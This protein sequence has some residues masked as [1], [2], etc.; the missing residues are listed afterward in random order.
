MEHPCLCLCAPLLAAREPSVRLRLSPRTLS[1]TAR[2][3]CSSAAQPSAPSRGAL[4]SRDLSHFL[5]LLPIITTSTPRAALFQA[6]LSLPL[7]SVIHYQKK[8]E[9]KKRNSKSDSIVSNDD[10]LHTIRT[11]SVPCLSVPVHPKTP[12][13]FQ[14]ICIFLSSHRHRKPEKETRGYS[15]P[16]VHDF[17]R[18]F[19][20]TL[21]TLHWIPIF[22][23]PQRNELRENYFIRTIISDSECVWQLFND[24]NLVNSKFCS[25]FL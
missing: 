22:L 20:F 18:R 24:Q 7:P 11:R 3:S 15:F 23:F 8:K 5:S 9:R 4:L 13:K 16:L 1:P 19:R 14:L 2:F 6:P 21:S 17:K 12:P 10:S 25:C